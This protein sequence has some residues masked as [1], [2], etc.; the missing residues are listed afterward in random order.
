LSSDEFI[1]DTATVREF[2]AD[3]RNTISTARSPEEACE[4]IRPAFANLLDEREPAGDDG[5]GSKLTGRS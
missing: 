5:A 3:V 2:V 1:L 4:T